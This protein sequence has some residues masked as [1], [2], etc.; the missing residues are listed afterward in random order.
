MASSGM[1]R[2]VALVSTDV[3]EELSASFIRVTGIGELGTLAH[4]KCQFL[5]GV[6][7]QKTPFCIVPSSENEAL[8]VVTMKVTEECVLHSSAILTFHMNVLPTSLGLN[9]KPAVT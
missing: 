1:L 7:T 5:H 3:L 2:C 6:T 8:M 9:S 4:P